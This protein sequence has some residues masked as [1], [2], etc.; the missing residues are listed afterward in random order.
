LPYRFISKE[1]VQGKT[2]V[3]RVDFNTNV[4]GGKIVPGARLREHSNTLKELASKGAK[5]IVLAH[6]GRKGD[7]DFISLKQ[8]AEFVASHT[9][10][11]VKFSSWEGNIVEK[12]KGLHEGEILIM[13]NTRFNDG[14][15][16]DKS[17]VEHSKSSWVKEI[18][19][20]ADFFVLDALS[21][22]HRAHASVIG[23][24]PLLPSYVGILLEKEL[25]AL[26][27]LQG[28]K[29]DRVLVLGGAKPGDS[30]KLLGKMLEEGSV[31]SALIGGLFAELFWKSLGKNFGAKDSFLKEKGFIELL[32]QFKQLFSKYEEKISLPLDFAVE[33]NKSRKNISIDALPTQNPT[34]DIGNKTIDLFKEKIAEAEAIVFNGPMGVYERELFQKGTR[35]ILTAIAESKAFSLL[36]GGDTETALEKLAI[37]AEKFSHVSLAGKALLAYLSGKE[38]PGLIALEQ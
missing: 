16:E 11:T 24:A 31:D 30:I 29:Q 26:Q 2:I 23:F 22:A 21:V 9:S 32:P 20:N 7:K 27:K 6:Q 14:E 38:L 15:N 5:L 13:D 18:A 25:N 34:M 4:V 33:E 3:I 36:G 8:H 37:P 10:L 19:N 1:D 12:I 35:E 28:F 17:A